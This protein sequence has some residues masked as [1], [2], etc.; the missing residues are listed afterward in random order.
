M[1]MVLINKSYSK[2]L[3]ERSTESIQ[4]PRSCTWLCIRGGWKLLWHFLEGKRCNFCLPLSMLLLAE[5]CHR[6]GVLYEY[7]C[8]SYRYMYIYIYI[9]TLYMHIYVILYISIQTYKQDIN[10]YIY[11]THNMFS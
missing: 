10:I 8:I 6:T 4:S 7:V 5:G 1:L 3:K 2:V 11:S 9:H